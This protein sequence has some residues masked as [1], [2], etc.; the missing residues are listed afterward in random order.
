M[1]NP[2]F[3]GGGR[4]KLILRYDALLPPVGATMTVPKNEY[5]T[6]FGATLVAS[7]QQMFIIVIVHLSSEFMP[8]YHKQ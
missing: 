1:K 4:R 6:A 7:R 3:S 8:Q 2:P 5:N